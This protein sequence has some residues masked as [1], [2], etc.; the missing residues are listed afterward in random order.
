MRSLEIGPV[1]SL[2]SPHL[3]KNIDLIWPGI[4]Q[5]ANITLMLSR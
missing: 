4:Y 2:K 1:Q 5:V 3:Q